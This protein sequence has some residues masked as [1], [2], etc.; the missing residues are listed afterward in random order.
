[1]LREIKWEELTSHRHNFSS[2][3]SPA[4]L[5]PIRL[6]NAPIFER[7]LSLRSPV[8]VTSRKNLHRRAPRGRMQSNGVRGRCYQQ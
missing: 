2:Q 7:Q 8:R 5:V 4:L 1:M 3:N 6:G